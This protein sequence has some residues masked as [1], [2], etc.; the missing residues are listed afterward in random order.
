[1]GQKIVFGT[2]TVGDLRNTVGDLPN[3]VGDLP[4]T[5]GDLS[6][7]R[8]R[9]K[10]LQSNAKIAFFLSEFFTKMVENETTHYHEILG[11]QKLIFKDP[12]I[13]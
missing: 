4:N 12:V 9:L 1:M 2:N 13:F 6:N 10:K 3:T 7:N 11:F 5:V 8:K